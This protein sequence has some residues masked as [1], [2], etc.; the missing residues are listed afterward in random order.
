MA[1]SEFSLYR[2]GPWPDPERCPRCG[3]SRPPGALKCGLCRL[4]DPIPAG[5]CIREHDDP[6]GLL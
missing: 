2:H 4:P 3:A 6:E 1:A 5:F